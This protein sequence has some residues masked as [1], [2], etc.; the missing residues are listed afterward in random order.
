MNYLLTLYS[1]VVGLFVIILISTYGAILSRK[2]SF[3]YANLGVISGILYCVLGFLISK[4]VDLTTA[5]IIN[6]LL[7]LIDST[8]GF[9]LSIHFKANNGY[10]KKQSLKMISIKTSIGMV[11]F[12]MILS[13]VGYGLTYVL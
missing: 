10:S 12:T 1:L 3:N 7:G 13:S 9:L 8:L 11:L 2:L 4:K 5:L 6:G